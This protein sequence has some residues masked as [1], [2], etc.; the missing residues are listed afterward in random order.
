MN[1]RKKLSASS[2]DYLE[3][4]Y[5]LVYHNRVARCRDIATS[6]DV[7]MA[8]VTGALKFLCDKE[9]VNYKPYGYI[10]LT[11]KG[12]KEALAVVRRHNIIESFFVNVLGVDEQEAKQ[13]ACK[14]EHS[15]GPA[16]VSRLLSFTEFYCKQGDIIAEFQNFC[17]SKGN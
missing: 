17:E 13:A 10:T 11:E 3:A 14:A 2:E 6:L 12:Q 16:I 5:N 9:L 1:S 8:S 4:I 7:S 15:L